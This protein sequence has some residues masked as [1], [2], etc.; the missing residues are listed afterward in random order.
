MTPS[1]FGEEH[2]E[3]VMGTEQVFAYIGATVVPVRYY[4]TDVWVVAVPNFPVGVLCTV[5][6]WNNEYYEIKG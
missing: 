3:A 4:C 5:G 1:N 2:A 6:N